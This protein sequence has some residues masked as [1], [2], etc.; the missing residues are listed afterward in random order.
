MISRIQRFVDATKCSDSRLGALEPLAKD[1]VRCHFSLRRHIACEIFEI[2]LHSLSVHGGES[3]VV[4]RFLVGESTSQSQWKALIRKVFDAMKQVPGLVD[5]LWM[6]AS[7]GQFFSIL[8]QHRSHASNLDE[9]RSQAREILQEVEKE[10]LFKSGFTKKGVHMFKALVRR[11]H[12]RI[13]RTLMSSPP[14]TSHKP[15]PR[16]PAEPMSKAEIDSFS[17]SL[18]EIPDLNDDNLDEKLSLQ[19]KGLCSLVDSLDMQGN[20]KKKKVDASEH[21]KPL[22]DKLVGVSMEDRY[23]S[24]LSGKGS[25]E[26]EEV[27]D[28]ESSS[29]RQVKK[30]KGSVR[31]GKQGSIQKIIMPYHEEQGPEYLD[32]VHRRMA[33]LCQAV[34]RD[35]GPSCSFI[36]AE[37]GMPCGVACT[38]STQS[39][40]RAVQGPA[41]RPPVFM[42]GSSL[43]KFVEVDTVFLTYIS[44]MSITNIRQLYSYLQASFL[45][46]L[47]SKIAAEATSASKD[48]VVT[49]MLTET[50]K[51]AL[52][53]DDFSTLSVIRKMASLHEAVQ[54]A[55]RGHYNHAALDI[56]D[57]Y[58]ETQDGKLELKRLTN[59]YS[60]C[61]FATRASIPQVMPEVGR[62]VLSM[63]DFFHKMKCLMNALRNQSLSDTQN[64]FFNK[65]HC[66][67]AARK[68]PA[69]FSAI[70]KALTGS[71][72][73]QQD[74][75][76][77][78]QA[79]VNQDFLNT[80][81]NDGFPAMAER[82]RI[83]GRWMEM[84][85]KAGVDPIVREQCL[86]HVHILVMR[87]LE[88]AGWHNVQNVRQ[89]IAGLPRKLLFALAADVDSVRTLISC[90]CGGHE[91]KTLDND[92]TIR[93][94]HIWNGPSSFIEGGASAFMSNMKWYNIK[95]RYSGTYDSEQG[96]SALV[97]LLGY[98]PGIRVALGAMRRISL[99]QRIKHDNNRLI[100]VRES[101]RAK[102][103]HLRDCKEVTRDLLANWH[104]T[105]DQPSQ[106]LDSRRESKRLKVLLQNKFYNPRAHFKVT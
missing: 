100:T 30:R 68:H 54:R 102:Y 63:E 20:S 27:S 64:G 49:Q 103:D 87:A 80:L 23:F 19:V 84:L 78:K 41:P 92:E 96:F 29:Q 58:F 4:A 8:W 71:R 40:H 10:D 34:L 32:L 82:M 65:R 25:V 1:A 42:Q 73:D 88:R 21:H 36:E 72:H 85:D 7:D 50:R 6:W 105:R 5:K 86:E 2:R 39:I 69:E 9:V 26:V 76:A 59:A 37:D 35:S 53:N 101:R 33:Y 47:F 13:I 28:D 15:L 38:I 67:D 17:D 52:E 16:P 46:V 14:L 90:F 61:T 93:L 57:N 70:V 79:F 51:T 12:G 74:P 81:S 60:N 104:G 62:I 3:I 98:K 75:F 94:R 77:A 83:L 106:G 48:A 31:T 43:R 11:L 66:L 18:L 56:I 22:L 95:L 89:T 44:D 91:Q 99:V 24:L 55:A 97:S 45:E